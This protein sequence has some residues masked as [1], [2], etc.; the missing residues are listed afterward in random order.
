MQP[1]EKLA[2]VMGNSGWPDIVREIAMRD[3]ASLIGKMR[4]ETSRTAFAEIEPQITPTIKGVFFKIMSDP[5]ESVVLRVQAMESG[6]GVLNNIGMVHA[7]NRIILK[8]AV[9]HSEMLR[10]IFSTPAAAEGQKQG[11]VQDATFGFGGVLYDGID[12][13]MTIVAKQDDPAALRAGAVTGLAMLSK[14]AAALDLPYDGAAIQAHIVKSFAPAGT[15][16][17]PAFHPLT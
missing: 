11:A 9:G 4:R 8:K 1:F 3:Y 6:M 14:H 13:M 17:G 5:A 16:C 7:H 15:C 12:K 2:S 10:H